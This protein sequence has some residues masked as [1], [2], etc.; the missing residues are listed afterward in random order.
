ME[1]IRIKKGIEIN[2]NDNGDVVCIDVEDLNFV[3]RY[4]TLIDKLEKISAEAEGLTNDVEAMEFQV[5][6]MKILT[7]EIDEFFN[8]NACEKIFGKDVLPTAFAVAELFAQLAPIINKY[9]EDRDKK[10]MS[11]YSPNRRGKNK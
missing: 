3:D 9:V 10:I 11:E 6:K 7:K 4:K 2:V 8:D 5:E 1:Q